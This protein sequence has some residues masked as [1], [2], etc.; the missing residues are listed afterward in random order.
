MVKKGRKEGYLPDS[1]LQIPIEWK[2]YKEE[3]EEEEE[4]NR[5]FQLALWLSAAIEKD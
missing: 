3:E 2:N 4:G 1:C 5:S